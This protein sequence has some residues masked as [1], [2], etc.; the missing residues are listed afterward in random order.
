VAYRQLRSVIFAAFGVVA[1]GCG[2]GTSTSA[3]TDSTGDSPPTNTDRP[4]S[5]ADQAP[6]GSQT[7]PANPDAPP[8]NADA[9]PGNSDLGA[10]CNQLCSGI[11][12]AVD[13]CSQGT[14]KL[15]DVGDLCSTSCDIPPTVLP[16]ASE[17]ASLLQC[18]IGDLASLCAAS[19][20]SNGQE[21]APAAA[22]P[23]VDPCTAALT[24]AQ[25]CAETNHIDLSDMGMNMDPNPDP[26]PPGGDCNQD[27][28]CTQCVCKAGTDT[29]KLLAC[30]SDCANP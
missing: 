8:S 19:G 23:N 10:L 27:D 4:P 26:N 9:P 11:S 29:T 21:P 1:F 25:D 15:G 18:F 20:N 28:A 30:Q 22:R 6:S 24:A 5:G 7:P 3:S 12:D 17:L 13:H 14:A 16:C 2:G